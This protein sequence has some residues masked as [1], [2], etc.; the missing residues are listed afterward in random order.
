L[1]FTDGSSLPPRKKILFLSNLSI[2]YY[3][4]GDFVEAVKLA[5]LVVS[6]L[7]SLEAAQ[8]SSKTPAI[9]D[10]PV[11]VLNNLAVFNLMRAGEHLAQSARLF[12]AAEKAARHSRHTSHRSHLTLLNNLCVYA[13]AK[14][15][16][17]ELK[18][19]CSELNSLLQKDL[20]KK[21][22]YLINLA[23]L[24]H[25]QGELQEA[26]NLLTLL[27][28]LVDSEEGVNYFDLESIKRIFLLSSLNNIKLKKL[29]AF[30]Q[31]MKSYKS[32]LP[33][34]EEDPLA[35]PKAERMHA[36]GLIKFGQVEKAKRMLD[37]C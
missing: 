28:K 31:D 1:S 10:Q 24:Y 7:N 34:Q 13:Y 4:L 15:D 22:I 37:A 6:S 5:D 35:W 18:T 8:T 29:A 32:L 36:I 19:F 30:E 20:K 23:S 14:K 11:E 26:E 3:I 33:P 9:V 21:P 12:A 2:A 16:S 17:A 27:K 25:K